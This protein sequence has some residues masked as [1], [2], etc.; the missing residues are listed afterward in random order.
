MA[1]EPR[2]PER[3]EVPSAP[4]ELVPAE[5]VVAMR[6]GRGGL[7]RVL[8]GR[9]SGL[10]EGMVLPVVAAPVKDGKARLLGEA[11][12]V[13]VLPRQA[14]VDPDDR[15][16]NAGDVD[17]FLVLSASSTVKARAE[18]VKPEKA[19][20]QASEPQ[21]S[22][23]Q[24]SEPQAS[25]PQAS[26]PLAPLREVAVTQPS[27]A[28]APVASAPAAGKPAEPRELSGRIARAGALGRKLILTNTDSIIWSQCILVMQGRDMYKLGGMAPGGEREIAL[29]DFE[30][31]GHDVPY[32]NR[33]RLGLFC[34]EGR[35]EFSLKL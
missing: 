35:K 25:E 24:A 23:P 22:E 14:M 7:Y 26:E 33:N 6:E 12:V 11:T 29:R 32:V 9:K 8:G 13:Q 18:K 2:A 30:K 4:P 10:S 34:A 16:R 28:S 21:A 19:E 3:G 1:G 20:P 31:G 17:R 27:V 15:V 5:H